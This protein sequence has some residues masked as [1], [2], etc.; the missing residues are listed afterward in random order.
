MK[1]FIFLFSFFIISSGIAQKRKSYDFKSSSLHDVINQLETENNVTFSYAIDLI[2]HKQISLTIEDIEFEELLDLLESQTCLNF[3]LLSKDRVIIAP[4]TN[5]DLISVYILDQ[6]TNLPI[7]YAE[8]TNSSGLPSISDSNGFFQLRKNENNNFSI[9]KNGYFPLEFSANEGCQQIYLSAKNEMLNEVLVLGYVTSG[10]DRKKDGSIDVNSNSLGILPGLVS[11]DLLQSIQLIPGI[12]SL[13]ESASGIQIRGGTPDQ[14][15]ILLDD[16]KLFNTGYLYGMFSSINPHATQKANVFKSGTSAVY[17]DRISGIIDITTGE[18]IPEKTESGLGIDGLSIDGFVKTAISDKLAVYVFGRRSLDDIFRSP[19][20][21]SFA[22]KVFRNTGVVKN[23]NGEIIDVQSDDDY[24]ENSSTD[25]FSFHD[26]NAKVIFTPNDANTFI[27]SGLINQNALDFSFVNS[28]ERKADD[29][30]TTNNGLSF[31]WKHQGNGYN[32]EDISI[33]VSKYDS[34]YFNQETIDNVLGERNKISNSITD[35]GLNLKL[36]RYVSERN[37]LT[38]GYQISNSRVDIEVV[39]EDQISNEENQAFKNAYQNL[40]NALF[41]EYSYSTKNSSLIGIGLRT[42]HYSSLKALYLEPRLNIEYRLIKSLRLK[43]SLER[44]HQPISQIIEFDQGELR[45]ENNIWRLS[46]NTDSPLL[47]S[48][49]IS[50]GLLFD[51]KHWTIDFDAYYKKISGLTSQTSG[52]GNPQ[53]KLDEGESIIRGLDLLIKKRFQNY[54]IWAGYTY[55]NISFDFPDIQGG[56]FPGN[57]DIRHSFRISNSL[58]I[59]N[60]DISL[61]WQYRT[62]APYT[63]I[64]SYDPETS[65]VSFGSINSARL[66]DYHRLDASAIYD[67]KFSKS[68]K[69]SGQVGFSV[70]NIYNRE[71]PISYTYITEDEGAGL[72]LQQVIQKFSLGITPNA[73]F[74]IFF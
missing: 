40:K 17:G 39:Q 60:L 68:K 4:K 9:S 72:E 70:L 35:I 23:A 13:D 63:P 45:L 29:L 32:S 10:I 65:L 62:G 51:K 27:L 67:F 42:V 5:D 1:H 30:V 69:W 28:N 57:N 59:N 31:K 38:F 18:N 11:S 53:L 55:N 48:D 74:R 52:F 58:K 43:G 15:L 46:N 20:Y 33:Y 22:D 26:M 49:Q 19:T 61:G 8:I 41:A 25:S 37:L 66:E 6:E 71:V 3:K 21:E 73:S 34:D 24:T 36:N 12:N 54:R 47:R 16:I 14:N 7:P 2:A 50:T 44:R 64:T 56:N